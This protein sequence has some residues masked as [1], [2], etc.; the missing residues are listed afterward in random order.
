MKK[1]DAESPETK[2][3]DTVAGNIE[4]LKALFPEAFTEGKI[5]F[6]VLKGLLGAAVDERDEKYGLNWHGKRRARQIALT[7]STGTLLP[8]PEESVEWDTTRN[9]M[10]EGDNLEVLKL[11]QKSYTGKVKLIYIDPPYNTGNDF[12]YPDDFHESIKNY[13]SLT[14]QIE[15]G[16]KIS[17]NTETSGRFHTNWLNMMYPRLK[18][19]RQ[20]LANDGAIFISIDSNELPNLRRILDEIFGEENHIEDVIWAQNTTHSQSPLYSTNHEYIIVY[21]R[22]AA[23]MAAQ[24]HTFR[25]AKP[26]YSDLIELLEELQPQY[27]D[28][29][30]IES[31][32]RGLMDAHRARFLEELAAAGVELDGDAEKQD[33]WRGIYAYKGVEYRDSTGLLVQPSKAKVVNAKIVLWQSDNAAAPAGKQAASTKDPNDANYRFYRPLHPKTGKECPCP[34]T[35]WRWPKSW[36]DSSRESFDGYQKQDRIV[37]GVDHTTVPRFKR[38]IHEV[39]TNVSKSF[40]FDYS[41]GEKQVA[42]LFEESS[43]F[44]NP[45][46]TSLVTRFID[47][48]CQDGDLV[49]DFFAGS[50]T[51]G[52]AVVEYSFQGK[53]K[54]SFILVQLPEPIDAVSKDRKAA[55]AFCERINKAPTVA[56]L[57]KERLRRVMSR[58][59][60]KSTGKL[61]LEEKLDLGFRVFKLASSNISAWQPN[62]VDLEGSLFSYAEQLLPH[63]SEQ[64]VLY[65]LLLKLGLDL[66]VPI[67]TQVIVGKL[68]H[69]IGGGAL[70]ICLA[71]GLAREVIE[72]LACGINAWHRALSPAVETRVVFKD[73]G[74]ADD[75]AKTNMAAILNQ[76][77][78]S[79]VRSL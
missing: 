75:I 48:I 5:D 79:D 36:P 30:V 7:P 52:H 49:L 59:R 6:E 76:N 35:G 69:S 44:P 46:P 21:A 14:N 38:F 19:A 42:D 2:S 23:T 3:A 39:E 31:R 4:A 18:I 37:W 1:L 41:D 27:P 34:K 51:T 25:E 15:S 9:L 65:E 24:P 40:F 32:V 28:V 55:I 13:L 60:S 62:T 8:C 22:D 16:Q 66:C 67:E 29:D 12:V 53:T 45:K 71:D 61:A 43:I 78:I 77:G 11:L 20:L 56:E 54:C 10:I 58:L 74:F 33:P 57:T 72:P 64:D 70:F 47:Q 63:R 17:S 26:G 73:S 50:G 68:V